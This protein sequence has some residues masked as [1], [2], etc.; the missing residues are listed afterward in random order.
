MWGREKGGW[1]GPECN[2][3]EVQ[4]MAFEWEKTIEESRNIEGTI[5]SFRSESYF[6]SKTYAL[7]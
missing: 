7:C 5:M 4:A 2:D 3:E 6:A 1:L